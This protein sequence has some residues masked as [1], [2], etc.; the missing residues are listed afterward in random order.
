MSSSERVPNEIWERI[1]SHLYPSQLLW[2]SMVNKNFSIIV[3]SLE[4]WSQMFYVAHGPKAQLQ[5]L[6]P[7]PRFKSSYMIF[8]CASSLHVCEKCFGLTEYNANRLYILPLPIPI[9]LPRWSTDT[10]KYEG[11]RFDP[12]WT[13]WMCLHCRKDH[14]SDLEEPVPRNITKYLK[15]DWANLCDLHP[16]IEWMQG[17]NHKLASVRHGFLMIE[18]QEA[19]NNMWQYF[20]GDSSIKA[21]KDSTVAYD[22]KT[23]NRIQWYQLQE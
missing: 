4:V 16:C 13:I 20:S 22:E 17:R 5:L 8:M 9:L 10:I 6:V 15:M 19:F 12:N 2:M 23:E 3:S 11:D 14:L 21:Y 7:T 18:P 1:L